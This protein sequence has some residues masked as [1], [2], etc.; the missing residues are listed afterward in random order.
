MSVGLYLTLFSVGLS[1]SLFGTYKMVRV[2][3]RSR[4]LLELQVLTVLYSSYAHP[5]LAATATP[6]SPRLPR[7]STFPT[8]LSSNAN[9][10]SLT[11]VSTT[12]HLARWSIWEQG[13]K[14]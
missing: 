13:Q 5:A 6:T 8:T 10:D 12:D 9:L 3:L 1:G 2:R 14:N 4:L 11:T 7:I